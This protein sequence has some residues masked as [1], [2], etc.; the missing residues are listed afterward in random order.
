MR[1]G[2]AASGT[3][4]E[5]GGQCGAHALALRVLGDRLPDP[6]GGQGDAALER[7][8]QGVLRGL[9]VQWRD[10][11]DGERAGQVAGGHPAHAVGDGDEPGPGVQGVLVS[12]A[13]QPTVARP[14]GTQLQGHGRQPARRRAQLSLGDQDDG[15]W[16]GQSHVWAPTPRGTHRGPT[17]LVGHHKP[18]SR[19]D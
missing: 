15:V 1:Q 8:D 11:V 2:Q 17:A 12:A 16:R 13:D 6:C 7:G 10:R 9:Q 4:E 18:F 14:H 3:G 19:I 5:Q